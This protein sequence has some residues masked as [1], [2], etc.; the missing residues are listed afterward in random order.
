MEV[1]LIN[2]LGALL[3][4]TAV[5]AFYGTWWDLKRINRYAMIFGIA[6]IVITKVA[7]AMLLVNSIVLM[8]ITVLLIFSLSFY[9]VSDIARKVLCALLL[10]A[11]LF[12]VELFTVMV[13]VNMLG[14]A[15]EQVYANSLL[16]F[17]GVVISRLLVIFIAYVIRVVMKGYQKQSGNQ[18]NW[19]MLLMPLQSIIICFIVYFYSINIDEIQASPLGMISILLSLTLIFVTMFIV[20]NLQKAITYKHDY[21]LAMI[22]LSTQ[23]EHYQKLYQAQYEIRAIRHDLNNELIAISGMLDDSRIQ[24]ASEHIGKITS[25]IS[26][27]ATITDT[28]NPALDAVVNA[29][30]DKAEKS[31]AHIISKI[32]IRSDL[33]ID[34]FDLA[35]IIAPALDNAI[36]GILRSC[37]V[38]KEIYLS[39]DDKSGF[40]SIVVENHTSGLVHT[41][42]QTT[43]SDK[44]NHGFGIAQM[45]AIAEKYGGIVE[46]KYDPKLK[47]FSLNVLLKN[48]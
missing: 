41:D 45:R 1:I 22:K 24:E 26:K 14:V 43:K 25:S 34:G 40:I 33:V 15:M 6:A 36:E 16:Y 29:K 39:I 19:I 23:I 44:S 42:F 8:P 32:A 35:G 28:G 7:S 47:K 46:P 30:I 37:G 18:F 3:G 5:L 31:G 13:F 21:E 10:T 9:F 48:S 11:I 2:L 38:E 4:T 27:T 12:I 17:V 20:K